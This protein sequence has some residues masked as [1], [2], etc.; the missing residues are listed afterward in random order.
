MASTRAGIEPARGSRT[1]PGS[2]STPWPCAS[3]VLDVLAEVVDFDAYVW[4]LTDPVTTVGAAPLADVPGL[5][6]SELPALIRAKYATA[7]EPL[8]RPDADDLAR[9]A[10]E[11]RASDDRSR[12]RCGAIC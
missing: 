1:S 2:R 9:G 5:P 8:D 3:T 12:Q 4:L 7:R 10:A 6:L 11:Q